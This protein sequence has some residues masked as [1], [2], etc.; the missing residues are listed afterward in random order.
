MY[1]QGMQEQ[2]KR[3]EPKHKQNKK[4]LLRNKKL[5][6]QPKAEQSDALLKIQEIFPSEM[7][8]CIIIYL[9]DSE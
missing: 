5:P 6:V 4:I 7:K 1:I 9:L 2:N 8:G 3:K